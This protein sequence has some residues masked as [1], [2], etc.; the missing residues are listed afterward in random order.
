VVF[1]W[2]SFWWLDYY[3]G[4]RNHLQSRFSCLLANERV[5]VFNLK[6]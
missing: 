2:P 4:L 3:N 1:A 6:S 5:V